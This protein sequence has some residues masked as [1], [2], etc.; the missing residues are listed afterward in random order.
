MVMAN[1]ESVAVGQALVDFAL[2]GGFPEED[3]STRRVGVQ[4]FGPALEAL[5]A[6]KA[7]LEVMAFSPSIYTHFSS[8]H[9]YHSPMF[10]LSTKKPPTTCN[11]G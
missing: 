7:K 5:A 10:T 6:A 9:I 2:H 11:H 4:D 1:P 8:D 3:V